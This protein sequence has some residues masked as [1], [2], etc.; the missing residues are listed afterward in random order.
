[1]SDLDDIGYSNWFKDRADDQKISA[2]GVARIV[3]VHKDSY[4]VTNGGAE[5]FAEL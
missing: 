1:M 2:H 4:A 3:A 5:I